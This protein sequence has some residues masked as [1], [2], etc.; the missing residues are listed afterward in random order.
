[1]AKNKKPPHISQKNWDDVE[2][3]PFSDEMLDSMRPMREVFPD[4]VEYALKRKRGRPPKA[5]PKRQ[6][7]VRLSE[8]VVRGIKASGS[9]YNA[10]MEKVLRQALEKGEF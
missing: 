1:M 4:L 10:R 9:N 7:T 2:S 6:M 8:D 3:S 5:L